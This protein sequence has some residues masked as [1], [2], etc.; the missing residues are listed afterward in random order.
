MAVGRAVF[1]H[2]PY[3]IE[4]RTV[5]PDGRIRWVR[6]KGRAYYDATGA[7]TRFDGVTLDVTA[8]KLVEQRRE[9]LLATERAAR[10]EAERVIRMKDEFLATLS[11]ELRTP[12]NAILGW[13]QILT[14]GPLESEDARQGLQAIERNTRAQAQMIE[15]LLDMSRI[16]AGK[17]RLDVTLL[18]HVVAQAI[19]SVRPSAEVKGLRLI[20]V[21]DPKAGPIAGDAGR[22]Q[23]VVWNLLTN[24]IIHSARRSSASCP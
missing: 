11:H 14:R 8:L 23:Q 10:E 15:D 17:V 9:N 7:P 13:S 20:A 19:Q 4:Y 24:A 21:I 3:D 12:L 6:A 1:H 18:F 16:T 22:L 2:E 5:A